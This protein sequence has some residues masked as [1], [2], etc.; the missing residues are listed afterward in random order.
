MLESKEETQELI[1]MIFASERI[2]INNMEAGKDDVIA[3]CERLSK[4]K[5]RVYAPRCFEKGNRIEKILIH[6]Y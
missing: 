6:T 2:E 5:E 1:K 3:L 4:G